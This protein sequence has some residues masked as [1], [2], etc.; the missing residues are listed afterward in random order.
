M[1]S[2]IGWGPRWQGPYQELRA[3]YDRLEQARSGFYASWRGNPWAQRR[4]EGWYQVRRAE[5][6]RRAEQLSQRA[7]WGRWP[8]R[9]FAEARHHREWRER[10]DD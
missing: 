1:D 5:L 9:A 6:D 3:E 10:D 4:F 2:P 7:A 8:G